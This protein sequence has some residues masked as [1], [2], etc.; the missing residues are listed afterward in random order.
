MFGIDRQA[1]AFEKCAGRSREN[2]QSTL[3][4]ILR[5]LRASFR[6]QP[7]LGA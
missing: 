3:E 4:D 7:A 6:P 1:V 5:L 2:Y